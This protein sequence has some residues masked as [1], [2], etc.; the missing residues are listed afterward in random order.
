MNTGQMLIT[1]G[2][3]ILLSVIILRTN[4]TVLSTNTVMVNSK[5]EVLAVSLATSFMEEATSKK[6][7]EAVVSN[8]VHSPSQLSDV[9]GPDYHEWYPFFDD[10]DDYNYFKDS[11]KID[12][13]E[14]GT[15]DTLEFETHAR[16]E[17]VSDSNPDVASG[18]KTFNKKLT[19]MVTSPGMYDE[20]TNQQDTLTMSTIFSYWY[21]K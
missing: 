10:I 7:D 15:N 12:R 21:F 6:F 8:A 19:V 5:V 4:T 18:S 1:I 13:I 11:V 3:I 16:V 9:L 14:I 2:A 20:Q 17:Y